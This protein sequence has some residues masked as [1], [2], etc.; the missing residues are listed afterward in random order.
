MAK[1]VINRKDKEQNYWNE[2][3]YQIHDFKKGF[4]YFLSTNL[5]VVICGIEWEKV[6]GSIYYIGGLDVRRKKCNWWWNNG[7]NNKKGR[8]NRKMQEIINAV[9]NYSIDEEILIIAGIK[10]FI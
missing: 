2:A 9:N 8:C 4:I 5:K 6:I 7:F 3:S 10:I 1:K